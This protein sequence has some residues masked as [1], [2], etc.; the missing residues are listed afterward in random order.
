MNIRKAFVVLAG[1]LILPTIA[2]AQGGFAPPELAIHEVRENIYVIRSGFSGNVTVLVSD[3]G[4]VLVDDKFEM[5]HDGV[6][7]LI[8]S[9][10]DQ[11]VRYVINTHLHGDHTGGNA[12]MQGLGADV[13]SSLNA[14]LIMAE[15]QDSGL[16]NITMTDYMRV[17]L[18]DFVIDLHYMGRGH[19]DGDIVIHLPE[20]RLVIMGDLFALFGPYESVVHYGAGGSLRDWPRS[21]DNALKLDFDT[22]IPGHSGL[23]DRS[24]IEGYR[25]YLTRIGETVREMNQAERSR[26]DIQAVL[27]SEFGWGGLSMGLGLD[28]VITEM[29]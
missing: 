5:D 23:T 1:L 25:D 6:M 13:I 8:R 27:E 10:T 21:L 22:V 15:A 26:E 29:R 24:E 28:G 2:N 4:V 20:E 17:Y 3:E 11:P 16:P 7:E 9:V 14:R 18:G 19:T 12:R